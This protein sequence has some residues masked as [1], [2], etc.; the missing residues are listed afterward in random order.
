MRVGGLQAGRVGLR[1]LPFTP[2]ARG[3]VGNM[4]DRERLAL[5]QKICP[6]CRHPIYAG[7]SLH[8]WLIR[9]DKNKLELDV[10]GYN[11]LLVH[12]DHHVPEPPEFGY[13]CACLVLG[14]MDI[15]PEEIEDWVASLSYKVPRELPSHY[16]DARLELFGY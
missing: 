12:Q 7:D 13:K 14:E 9:R 8:H 4:T 3:S 2:H 15:G 16:Y 11:L 1:R 5:W 10:I 6:V